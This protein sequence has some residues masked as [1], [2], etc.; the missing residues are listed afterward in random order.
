MLEEES[1]MR[2]GADKIFSDQIIERLHNA[3]SQ[4]EAG[5]RTREGNYGGSTR[6]FAMSN[7]SRNRMPSSRRGVA[8]NSMEAVER[9]LMMAVENIRLTNCRSATSARTPRRTRKL[10]SKR[11]DSRT[12]PKPVTYPKTLLDC[13]LSSAHDCQLRTPYSISC[14]S[15]RLSNYD[16]FEILNNGARRESNTA[17]I[18]ETG[19]RDDY[20]RGCRPFGVG[21]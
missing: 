10:K 13:A 16:S 2:K 19:C 15:E 21:R 8:F 6:S 1:V 12:R 18:R 4:E 3:A 9:M 14:V 7:C 11:S 20:S 5:P 17:R